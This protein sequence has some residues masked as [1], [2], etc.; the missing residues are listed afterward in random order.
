MRRYHVRF[1]GR[2]TVEP[3]VASAASGA[4]RNEV[5]IDPR[6]LEARVL[7]DLRR[8][9]RANF[10]DFRRVNGSS[11][12]RAATGDRRMRIHWNAAEL[13]FRDEVRGVPGRAN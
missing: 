2:R 8:T 13:A 12:V 10:G 11:L 3:A 9:R 5:L 4:F 1:V 7:L 6:S